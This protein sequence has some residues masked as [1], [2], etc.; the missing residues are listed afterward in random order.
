MSFTGRVPQDRLK[1]IPVISGQS[2]KLSHLPAFADDRKLRLFLGTLLY[3][4]QGFPQGVVFYA[5]PSWL[6][7]NGQGAAIVGMAA[8]AATM[9]WMAKWAVGAVMDRYTYLP[10]GRRRPWLI[11]SQLGIAAVF[12][13]FAALAPSPGDTLLVVGLCF[14]VSSL[15]AIQDIALDALVIDLTPDEEKGQLNGFMFGGKLF[16]IAGGVAISG[17]FMQYHGITAAMLAMLALF[18]IPAIAAIAIRERPGEKLLPWTDGETSPAAL[19]IKPKAWQPIIALAARN[20]FRRDT[21]LV[22]ALLVVFGVHQTLWEQGTGLFAAERLGW[23]E[24]DLGSLR[25]AANIFFGL[26]SLA[27]GGRLIDRYGPRL[28]ALASGTAALVLIAAFAWLARDSTS[29]LVYVGFAFAAGLPAML[30]YLA[31]LVLAMRVSVAEVAATSFALIVATHALGAT[32]GGTLLGVVNDLGG[33][34][35][36]FASAAVLIFLSGLMTLGMSNKAAGAIVVTDSSA[37]R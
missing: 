14:I 26:F 33:Y 28:I 16:G 17:Y 12:V 2:V 31:F 1:D 8:S 27:I 21:L 30:F 4:A 25:A 23:G 34:P 22:I 18:S 37:G 9:P 32:V 19:A 5:I 15:T 36:L 3:L 13:V 24:G 11:G 20:L 7:V 10:M 29:G 35:L 6:A